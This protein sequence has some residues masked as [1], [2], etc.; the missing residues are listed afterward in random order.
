MT[1]RHLSGLLPL[2]I[3]ATTSWQGEEPTSD[4]Q[5]PHSRSSWIVPQLPLA[6]EV[7][8]LTGEG[9]RRGNEVRDYSTIESMQPLLFR[10]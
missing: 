7:K 1:L 8:E 6:R 5:V 2:T 3:V 9:C 10:C 4:L